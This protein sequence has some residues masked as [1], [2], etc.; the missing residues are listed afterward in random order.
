MVLQGLEAID[1]AF[2][3]APQLARLSL[4]PRRQNDYVH[5]LGR[6]RRPRVRFCFAMSFRIPDFPRSIIVARSRS[7]NGFPSAVPCIST[8][9]PEP[10]RTRFMSTSAFESSS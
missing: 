5:V 8:N 1:G 6:V 7:E 2:E 3:E 10:V 4:V 9:R